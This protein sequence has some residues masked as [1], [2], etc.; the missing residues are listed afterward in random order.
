MN[1]PGD[2][3]QASAASAQVKRFMKDNGHEWDK[4]ISCL[5][6][7]TDPT[8]AT[9]IA[10]AAQGLDGNVHISVSA[11]RGAD[12]VAL[13]DKTPSELKPYLSSVTRILKLAGMESANVEVSLDAKSAPVVLDKFDSRISVRIRVNFR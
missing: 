6:S 9:A 11:Q 10:S 13:I 3:T 8:F 4:L 1:S 2:I 12:G 5:V 7:A